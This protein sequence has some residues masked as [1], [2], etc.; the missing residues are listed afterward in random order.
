MDIIST[1]RE[2]GKE[3]QK[4][5]RYLNMRL[6]IQNTDNDSDLQDLIGKF[7]LKRIS[8]E[9][10]TKKTERDNE[11]MQAL[12]QDINAIYE[13]IMQNTNM[14]AYNSAK[15]ELEKLLQRVNAIITQSA[16]GE[17]PETADYVESSCGGNCSSC[18]GCH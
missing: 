9:E 1:A 3:I 11:K 6:A 17:D 5:Q 7:N 12:Q 16:N 14:V 8:I 4:D 10:E 18:G 2:I 13:K 15:T